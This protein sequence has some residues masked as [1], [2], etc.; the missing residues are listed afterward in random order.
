MCG[1]WLK[2]IIRFLSQRKHDLHIL[3]SSLR[4]NDMDRGVLGI[5]MSLRARGGATHQGGAASVNDRGVFV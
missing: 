3:D 5:L 4:R 2:K 1:C